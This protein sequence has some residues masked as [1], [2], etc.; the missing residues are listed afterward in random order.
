[1]GHL[2]ISGHDVIDIELFI[3][4]GTELDLKGRNGHL[5][6]EDNLLNVKGKRSIGKTKNCVFV[7]LLFVFLCVRLCV[8]A[9]GS[10]VELIASTPRRHGVVPVGTASRR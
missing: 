9:S 2:S 5:S 3:A 10:S 1:M 6:L 4:S 7:S 8:F